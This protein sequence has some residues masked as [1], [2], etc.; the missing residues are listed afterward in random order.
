MNAEA[1]Y[2]EYIRYRTEY[3]YTMALLAKTDPEVAAM[4]ARYNAEQQARKS[5]E[6]QS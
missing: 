5:Q 3:P 1:I 6:S 4:E 2:Q